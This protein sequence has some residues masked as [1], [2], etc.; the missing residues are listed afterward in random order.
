MRPIPPPAI[1][2]IIGRAHSKD[3]FRLSFLLKRTFTVHGSKLAPADEQ[4]PILTEMIEAPAPETDVAVPT[5]FAENLPERQLCDVIVLATARSA[6]P[7]IERTLVL[8]IDTESRRILVRG[9]RIATRQG[10]TWTMSSPQPW[11]EM[12]L[13]WDRAYGG[14]DPNV[15]PETI[16]SVMEMVSALVVDPGM[17]P[18]NDLGRGFVVSQASVPPDAV[19]QLPNLEFP[20]DQLTPQR[21]PCPDLAAWH[22]QPRP[23]GFGFVPPHWFPRSLHVGVVAGRWPDLSYGPLPE[24]ELGLLPQGFLQEQRVADEPAV[25]PGFLQVSAPGMAFQSLSG[26]ESLMLEGLDGE[27]S[28]VSIVLPGGRPTAALRT[29][30]ETV[31]LQPR[32]VQVLLDLNAGVL[33]MLWSASLRL[34]DPVL[35]GISVPEDLLALP[36]AV[37]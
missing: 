8:R 17:Y 32:L 37:E 7:V 30:T 11:Q 1:D 20:D 31:D 14:T 23:A 34:D 6:R 15:L 28:S 4:E 21:L 10:N 33:T 24:E 2:R 19:L 29:P 36:I 27:H 25:S 22:R 35:K 18:R 16:D 26:S 13:G 12:P 9:N 5:R 3:F